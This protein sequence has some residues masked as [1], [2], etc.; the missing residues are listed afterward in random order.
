MERFKEQPVLDLILMHI[1]FAVPAALILVLFSTTP[2]GAQLLAVVIIYNIIL[3]LW[4]YFRNHRDWLDLWLFVVPLSILMIFPDWFLS[5][6]L[7][8]LS[9][10]VDGFPMIGSIPIYMAGLWAI[11]LFIILFIGVTMEMKEA[12]ILTYVSVVIISLLLFGGSE[13]TL[14]ML[15][16][17]YAHDV[18]MIGNV[19]I[20]II[21]PELILG[22]S[23][24]I[25]Y[26]MV[27]E[28]GIWY[29]LMAAFSIM[30]FYIG[31]ASFFY[32]LIERVI[33]GT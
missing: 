33:L 2:I 10:P 11:P 5:N 25:G 17:W 13:A 22:L 4:A 26:K 18:T 12:P 7:N 28:K 23:T 9:F 20:Y 16:S 31:N 21:I 3:P 29:K 1:V 32:F 14:W 24:Y 27:K 6:Q 8:V 15:G 19:A 30:V